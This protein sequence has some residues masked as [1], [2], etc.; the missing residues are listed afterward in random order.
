MSTRS[1][2]IHKA[3]SLPKGHPER[4]KILGELSRVARFDTVKPMPV[5]MVG[6]GRRGDNNYRRQLQ[7]TRDLLEAASTQ[8]GQ[9]AIQVRLLGQLAEQNP[10]DRFLEPYQ[11]WQKLE[12]DLTKKANEAYA[13]FKWYQMRA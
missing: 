7:S 11:D 6:E 5:T 10:E 9:A 13:L 12:A 1:E 4:K 3:A 2:L 8:A